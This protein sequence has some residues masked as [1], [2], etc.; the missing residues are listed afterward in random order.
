MANDK[1]FSF[2]EIAFVKMLVTIRNNVSISQIVS[3]GVILIAGMIISFVVG[4]IVRKILELIVQVD[5][6]SYKK[7]CEKKQYKNKIF[8]LPRGRSKNIMEH[9][10][11]IVIARLVKMIIIGVTLHGCIL[12]FISSVG[13]INISIFGFILIASSAVRSS[14]G[15]GIWILANNQIQRGHIIYFNNDK[16]TFFQIKTIGWTHVTCNE[17]TD[18]IKYFQYGDIEKNSNNEIFAVKQLSIPNTHLMS[19]RVGFFWKYKMI[20]ESTD[21]YKIN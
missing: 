3:C 4:G 15:A 8:Y 7:L 13:G 12:G 18:M 10:R 20:N 16:N 2:V 11:I 21:P 14:L 5:K 1:S 17:V 6:N 19:C 9:P